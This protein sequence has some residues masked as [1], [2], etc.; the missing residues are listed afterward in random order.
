MSS[1]DSTLYD[2]KKCHIVSSFF[3]HLLSKILLCFTVF[4]QIWKYSNYFSSLALLY[5]TVTFFVLI[6][7]PSG[8]SWV[9]ISEQFPPPWNTFLETLVEMLSAGL[10]MKILQFWQDKNNISKAKV[11]IKCLVWPINSYYLRK[12]SSQMAIHRT[13]RQVQPHL[14]NNKV[15]EI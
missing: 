2:S 12:P 10:I 13:R 4:N 5:H 6:L 3:T 14:I 1:V 11:W 7:W 8:S 9:R 15:S